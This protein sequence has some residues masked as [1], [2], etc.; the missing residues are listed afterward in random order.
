MK[1]INVLYTIPNFDTA[2]SGKVVYDLVKY[3]DKS[4]FEVTIVCSNSKGDF[5]KEVESLGVPI[6]I[7]EFT[8][9]YR[10]YISLLKRIRFYKSFIK[11]NQFSI[12]HSW[13]WSSDWTEVLA[14][15]LAGSKFIYTKKAMTWGNIHWKIRSFLSD[16]IIITNVQ[17]KRFFP[18]RKKIKLIP[19]GVNTDFF[20]SDSNNFES[21]QNKFTIITVANLVPVKK[22]ETIINALNHLKNPNIEFEIIGDNTTAYSKELIQLVIDLKLEKQIRFIGKQTDIR[23]FTKNASLYVI[24]SKME[25]MPV[26]LLEAMSL[27]IPVLG[28]KI[29]GINEV[30]KDFSMLMFEEGNEIELAMKI[31][32]IY[33]MSETQRA[34][35]GQELRSYCVEH[36]SIQKF[37]K[38]HE[39]LYFKLAHSSL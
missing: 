26:A 33:A 3:L 12:V 37:V 21:I 24:S 30:L 2:G 13:H 18:F 25:G 20:K 17:M 1:K 14:A 19:F 8:K 38:Q 9:P 27:G 35:L 36:F 11:E 15:K 16:Y 31:N 7:I 10:P 5:F 34:Q 4:K 29:P 22:I 28:S 6:H 23:S 32:Q 39:E